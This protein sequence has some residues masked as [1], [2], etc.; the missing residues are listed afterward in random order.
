[1]ATKRICSVINCN[2]PVY[3]RD[4]CEMHRARYRRYGDPL[5]QPPPRPKKTCSIAGCSKRAT[6]RGWCGAHYM[7]WRAHGDPLGGRTPDGEPERYFRSVVLTFAGDE[8]LIWPYGKSDNGYAAISGIKRM[9]SVHRY[10]CEEIHGPP[11][12]PTH[13]AAHSCGNGHMG[14]VNPKHLS[15]K[16]RQENHADKLL[17]GTHNRGERSPVAKLSAAQVREIRSMKGRVTQ[18]SLAKSF[19]VT[20]ATVSDILKRKTWRY[21]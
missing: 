17:H 21:L 14:C 20:R 1:M 15:W 10:A 5:G 13:E 11:P 16:T 19:G 6:Q 4:L 12:T 2:K 8:C 7:R 3:A 9:R 18:G